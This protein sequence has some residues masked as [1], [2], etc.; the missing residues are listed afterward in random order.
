MPDN[1]ESKLEELI[2]QLLAATNA[3]NDARK[4]EAD[5]AKEQRDKAQA[6]KDNKDKKTINQ[7]IDL[8]RL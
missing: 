4:D 6:K 7:L 2:K 5:R 8:Q 3:G 1:Q